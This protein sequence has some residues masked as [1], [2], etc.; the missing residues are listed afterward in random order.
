MQ[1][2][3]VTEFLTQDWLSRFRHLDRSLRRTRCTGA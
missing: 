3:S 2:V 1:I